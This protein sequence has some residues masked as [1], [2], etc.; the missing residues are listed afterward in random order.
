MSARLPSRR[1]ALGFVPEEGGGDPF[2]DL[3][4]EI[5]IDP[6]GVLTAG[7]HEGSG[8]LCPVGNED[9]I[10]IRHL[11]DV[12]RRGPHSLEW[13]EPADAQSAGSTPRRQS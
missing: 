2:S 11:V 10:G 9:R 12:R 6:T 7:G 1:G 5:D 3:V 8:E 4:E 13:H